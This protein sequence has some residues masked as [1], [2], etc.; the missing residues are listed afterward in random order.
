MIYNIY[1]LE[2]TIKYDIYIS[3]KCCVF[4]RFCVIILNKAIIY[5]C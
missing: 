1:K 4:G 3:T 5:D 2:K